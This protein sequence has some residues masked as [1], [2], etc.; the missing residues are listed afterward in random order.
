MFI[1]L[2][3]RR[4]KWRRWDLCVPSL[5]KKRKKLVGTD[6]E[7]TP[8]LELADKNMKEAIIKIFNHLKK[9]WSDRVNRQGISAEK[10][11]QKN[12]RNV[13][14]LKNTI[15]NKVKNSLDWRVQVKEGIHQRAN[16]V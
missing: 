6:P 11:K 16:I 12:H 3:S 14:E 5:R 1:C 15:G 2:R 9:R 7:M 13:L 10:W 4:S 8:M